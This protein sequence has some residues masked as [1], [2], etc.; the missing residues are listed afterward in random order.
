FVFGAKADALKN[1]Y[2]MRIITPASVAADQIW[3][4]AF[5]KWQKDAANFAWVELILTKASKLPYAVQIYSPGEDPLKDHNQLSRT[6][7]RLD[8][9]SVNS[10]LALVAGWLSNFAR[11]SPMGYRHVVNP[12]PQA[13]AGGPPPV[14][15]ASRARTQP[16]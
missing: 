4:E 3:L 7:I 8:S 11:P 16:R 1:R 2:Y 6:M 13:P 5:P 10:P 12:L 14:E 15:Q 9:P